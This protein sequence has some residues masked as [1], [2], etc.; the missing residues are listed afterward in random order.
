MNVERVVAADVLPHLTDRFEERQ[1]LD[2]ADGAAD[3]HQHDVTSLATV[4][5]RP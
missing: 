5:S 4:R 1:A 3:F 2:V